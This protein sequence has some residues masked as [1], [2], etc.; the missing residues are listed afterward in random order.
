VPGD[1][2]VIEVQLG[3][4]PRIQEFIGIADGFYRGRSLAEP[5]RA[6]RWLHS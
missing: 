4:A 6:S 1:I 2:G 5:K 3:G